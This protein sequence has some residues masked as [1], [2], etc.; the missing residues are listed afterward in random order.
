MKNG[1]SK[2]LAIDA[3]VGLSL[4]SIAGVGGLAWG[5]MKEKVRTNSENI[6]QL[7]EGEEQR[8]EILIKQESLSV[9]VEGM[10][11]EQKEFRSDMKTQLRRILQKLDYDRRR[12]LQ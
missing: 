8:T 1:L 11:Q 3:A 10:Q 6:L 12:D 4:L 2:R 5:Q 7:E 9:L